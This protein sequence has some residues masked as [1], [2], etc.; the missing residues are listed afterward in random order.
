MNT[1]ECTFSFPK[2]F[3]I[4]A[5]FD[6]AVR[7]VGL[8]SAAQSCSEDDTRYEAT[9]VIYIKMSALFTLSNVTKPV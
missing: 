6:A 9:N 4:F 5:S 7:V 8:E 2:L 3:S 1:A